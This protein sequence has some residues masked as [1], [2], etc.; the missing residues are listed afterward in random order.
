MYCQSC[1]RPANS[2]ITQLSFIPPDVGLAAVAVSRL[3]NPSEA[4]KRFPA[5]G[6]LP[7]VTSSDAHTINDFLSGPRTVFY[8]NEPTLS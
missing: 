4:I 7:I 6:N 8:I 1:G 5:I 2:L 3:T